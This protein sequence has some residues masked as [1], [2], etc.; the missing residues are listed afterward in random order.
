MQG[1]GLRPVFA[2]WNLDGLTEG[3][4]KLLLRRLG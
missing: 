3:K 4:R 2:R 1:L